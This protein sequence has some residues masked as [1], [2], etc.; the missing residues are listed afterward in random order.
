MRSS[1]KQIIETALFF[2]NNMKYEN[3]QR[4]HVCVRVTMCSG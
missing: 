1:S 2:Q 4:L 3:L